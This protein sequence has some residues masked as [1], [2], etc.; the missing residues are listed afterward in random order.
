M[1]CYKC[2]NDIALMKSEN[3][4][5]FT[6]IEKWICIP[7]LYKIKEHVIHFKEL[8]MPF[9]KAALKSLRYDKYPFE[10][11]LVYITSNCAYYYDPEHEDKENL[12]RHISLYLANMEG[13]ETYK[14]LIIALKKMRHKLPKEF[15]LYDLRKP[16]GME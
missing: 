5:D 9:T 10:K 4:F 7:C 1:K 8:V 2:N 13:Y 11:E 6:K 12:T 16:I 15:W 3:I 14:E